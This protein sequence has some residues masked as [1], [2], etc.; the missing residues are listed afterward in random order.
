[1]TDDDVAFNIGVVILDK[2]PPLVDDDDNDGLIVV[3]IV[4]VEETKDGE[5]IVNEEDEEDDDKGDIKSVG[6]RLDDGTPNDVGNGIIG[7]IATE[8]GRFIRP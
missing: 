6:T 5:G 8:G 1:M 4:V 3:L 7:E 2:V